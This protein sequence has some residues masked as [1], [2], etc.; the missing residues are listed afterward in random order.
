MRTI[1]ALTKIHLLTAAIV[2]I[3]LSSCES[4]LEPPLPLGRLEPAPAAQCADV[5]APIL[6]AV[7]AQVQ[8]AQDAGDA[9]EAELFSP[10][11][12]TVVTCGTGTPLAAGRA[13]SCTAVFASGLFL[14]FDAGDGAERSMERLNLPMDALEAVFLTHYHSDHIADLGEV[15]DRSWLLG[16]KRPLPIYGGEGL[17][18]VVDGF[19]H[20]YALDY[21]YRHAHHGEEVL[22]SEFAGAEARPVANPSAEGTIV[23]EKDGVTVMAFVVNHDPVVPAFGYRVEYAGKSIVISGDTKDTPSLA[24]MSEGADVLVSEVMNRTFVEAI[25]CASDEIGNTSNA[26]IVRDIRQYHIDVDE[27]AQLAEEAAVQTLVLTHL[28]PTTDDEAL[29]DTI[30]TAPVE[31]L[32]SGEVIAATDGTKVTVPVN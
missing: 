6:A 16:R 25:E 30:F 20:A 9:A 15:I 21:N 12:I 11:V 10:D 3:S 17:S 7:Q 32:F 18:R 27:L 23:Y 1:Q 13:Q 28:V 4:S 5:P 19:T 31:A 8:A 14:L 2:G 22:P 26:K 29:V 24:A